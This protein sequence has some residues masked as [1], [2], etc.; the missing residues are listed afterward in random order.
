MNNFFYFSYTEDSGNLKE[1]KD[2][3]KANDEKKE[4]EKD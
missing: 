2:E 4:K 1:N 3:T